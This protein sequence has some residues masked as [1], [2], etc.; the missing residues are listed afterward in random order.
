M[1]SFIDGY[2]YFAPV[3]I[4]LILVPTL[5]KLFLSEA[6]GK[7]FAKYTIKWFVVARIIAC[8]YGVIWTVIAFGLPLYSSVNGLSDAI[9]ESLSSLVWMLTHSVYFYAI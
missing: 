6:R 2:S 5:T 3:A 7:S 1:E 8:V 4:Y 9:K